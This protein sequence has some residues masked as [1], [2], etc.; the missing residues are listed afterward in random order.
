M[1][2]DGLNTHMDI[3]FV[4]LSALVTFSSLLNFVFLWLAILE[5]GK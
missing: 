3:R 2:E 4:A 5:M 1:E